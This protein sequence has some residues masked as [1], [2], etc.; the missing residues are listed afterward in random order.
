MLES[1]ERVGFRSRFLRVTLKVPKFAAKPRR[2]QINRLRR[3]S[4]PFQPARSLDLRDWVDG[5]TRNW[6][7][8]VRA[9]YFFGIVNVV[10]P[11]T[12]WSRYFCS[13]QRNVY[14]A[15]PSSTKSS[16]IAH[17][18]S[19]DLDHDAMHDANRAEASERQ[20]QPGRLATA[21]GAPCAGRWSFRCWSEPDPVSSLVT[22]R[23]GSPKKTD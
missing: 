1:A 17:L 15:W 3:R 18:K 14:Q 16:P 13:S 8:V 11:I 5:F 23:S 10:P 12:R 9:A 6:N 21:A 2:S 4:N 22:T 20:L 19:R 7:R